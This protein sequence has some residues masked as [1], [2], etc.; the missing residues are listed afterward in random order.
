MRVFI[1]SDSVPSQRKARVEV[2]STTDLRWNELATLAYDAIK[3]EA[4]L[5][6]KPGG[7]NATNYQPDR[8]ELLRQARMLLGYADSDWSVMPPQRYVEVVADIAMTA[9]AMHAR[10]E[11]AIS[12]SRDFVDNIV[13]WAKAFE[14]VY[15]HSLHGDVYI[16]LVD[17]YATLRLLGKHEEA[18]DI[19]RSMVEL[20]DALNRVET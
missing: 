3:T 5:A 7:L 18:E 15:K 1:E 9:G 19:L 11:I 17:Q 14:T 4:A 12:D 10:N 8:D 13:D 20:S 16:G 2:F 6:Y